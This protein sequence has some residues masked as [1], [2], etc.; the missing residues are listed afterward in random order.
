MPANTVNI[1]VKLSGRV[2]GPNLSDPQL[3]VIGDKMVDAQLARWSYGVNA[4]GQTAKKLSVRYAIIKQKFLHKRPKRDMWLTGRTAMNFLLRKAAVGR[5]RAEN[6]TRYEREKARSCNQYDQMIGFAVTD[7][8]AVTD[9]TQ[10]QYGQ[11]VQ[12]AWYPLGSTNRRPPAMN[13]TP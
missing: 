4:E 2:R 5:I 1:Q 11:Y 8:K 3:K 13:R 9:E 12:T 10:A 6:S 7:F